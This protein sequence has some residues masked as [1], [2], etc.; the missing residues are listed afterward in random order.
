MNIAF[1]IFGLMAGLFSLSNL[2]FALFFFLPLAK[3]HSSFYKRASYISPLKNLLLGP[4]PYGTILSFPLIACFFLIILWF[5]VRE[6]FFIY[7][8]PFLA[9]IGSSVFFG[10]ISFRDKDGK[11]KRTFN[12]SWGD[13][14]RS[15][16]FGEDS[17]A[18]LKDEQIYHDLPENI[19]DARARL[20]NNGGIHKTSPEVEGDLDLLLKHF[21]AKEDKMH[22]AII[23]EINPDETFGAIPS[24]KQGFVQSEDAYIVEQALLRFVIT[25]RK[26]GTTTYTFSSTV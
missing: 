13:N 1:F 14:Y 18:S 4:V 17:Q 7:S 16:F 21:K 5:F 24:W 10:L 23:A 9:G 12:L 8:V 19:K 20:L 6:F 3:K 22:E 15:L 26:D 11:H 2:L 25:K